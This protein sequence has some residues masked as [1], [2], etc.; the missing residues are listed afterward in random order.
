M[1]IF[2]QTTAIGLHFVL[3]TCTSSS[4]FLRLLSSSVS[5]SLVI[6]PTPPQVV[7]MRC[8]SVLFGPFLSLS[9]IPMDSFFATCIFDF[10]F[11]LIIINN[12]DNSMAW[13]PS[14]SILL[15]MSYN[16]TSTGFGPIDLL[17]VPSSFAVM[18]PSLTLSHKKEASLLSHGVSKVRK[19]RTCESLRQCRSSDPQ[20]A[21]LLVY[22]V[23]SAAATTCAT[24]WL[25]C[26]PPR[27][28]E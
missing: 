1:G 21:L 11:L 3:I 24:A 28:W 9:W 12:S 13:F 25:W 26:L 5:A 18:V 4:E 14:A 2:I 19:D 7:L 20:V 8:S 6:W 15:T 23:C 17:T 16:L 27:R 22:W 10:F